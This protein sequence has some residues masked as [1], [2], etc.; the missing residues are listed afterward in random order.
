M[1]SGTKKYYLAFSYPK[2]IYSNNMFM[3]QLKFACSNQSY[4]HKDG[5]LGIYAPYDKNNSEWTVETSWTEQ[6]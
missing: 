4:S 6:W 2:S 3:G 5:F 1:E